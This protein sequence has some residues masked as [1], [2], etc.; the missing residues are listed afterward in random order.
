M[1]RCITLIFF[2]GPQK[3]N[4]HSNS[5]LTI[6]TYTYTHIISWWLG[7]AQ[8]TRKPFSQRYNSYLLAFPHP[9]GKKK[10]SSNWQAF[11]QF[12]MGQKFQQTTLWNHTPRIPLHYHTFAACLIPPQKWDPIH[13]WSPLTGSSASRCLGRCGARITCE[14]WQTG[15]CEVSCCGMTTHDHFAWC[16]VVA[17][18]PR[19]DGQS[20][21]L[22]WSTL[23]PETSWLKFV[24]GNWE[25]GK[26]PLWEVEKRTVS[27]KTMK[28]HIWTRFKLFIKHITNQRNQFKHKLL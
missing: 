5:I 2:S 10:C 28:S 12:P 14:S 8:T 7:G 18:T 16:R 6:N 21:S 19:G 20:L 13:S 26:L 22:S 9:Y 24:A 23:A 15:W 25:S 4:T 11:Y 3:R 27:D 1:Y 17:A